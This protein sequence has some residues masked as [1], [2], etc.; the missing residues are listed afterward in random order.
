MLSFIENNW[1]GLVTVLGF[2]VTIWTLLRTKTAADAART[3]AEQTKLQ[4]SRVDTLAECSSALAIMDEI[5]RLHRAGAWEVVP[6]RYAALRRLLASI[7]TLNPDL[8]EEQR[9]AL[10]ASIGQFKTM[11]H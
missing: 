5:K 11:E 2:I 9:T 4:L 3:A 1:G 10:S 7:Q 8:T 6:D